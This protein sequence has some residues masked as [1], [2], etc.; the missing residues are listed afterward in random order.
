MIKITYYHD[1][2]NKD[3][4]AFGN[5]D[6]I[7]AKNAIKESSCILGSTR[8]KIISDWKESRRF[9]PNNPGFPLLSIGIFC[10]AAI[11]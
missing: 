1:K 9:F 10:C 4:A 2:N 7:F 3:C 5:N 11:G 8:E 6:I